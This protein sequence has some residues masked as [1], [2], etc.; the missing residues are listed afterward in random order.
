MKKNIEI[1]WIVFLVAILITAFGLLTGF[2]LSES[3]DIQMHDTYY[4]IHNLHIL[5]YVG[6]ILTLAYFMTFGLKKLATL[7]KP[8]QITSLLFAGLMGLAFWTLFVLILVTFS[9]SPTIGHEISTYGILFLII[10]L[11]LLFGLRTIEI[12]KTR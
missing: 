2:A 1:R 10:G 8:F 11:A 5:I 3:L 4:V 6:T 7:G 12:W 9:V